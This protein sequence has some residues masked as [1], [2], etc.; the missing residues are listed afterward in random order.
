MGEQRRKR[1]RWSVVVC[2]A[3]LAASCNG[4]DAVPPDPNRNAHG[5]ASGCPAVPD[6]LAGASTD[7]YK[8]AGRP[9]RLFIL[10]PA[11]A[12]TPR[13]AILFFFGGGWRTGSVTAFQDQAEAFRRLGYVAVLAEYRVRCRDDTTCRDA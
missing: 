5:E 12:Q 8:T 9:L 11:R 1:I 6:H 10:R 3:M 4:F 13:P 7:I 2:S